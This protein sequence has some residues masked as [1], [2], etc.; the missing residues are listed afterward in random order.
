MYLVTTEIGHP[1]LEAWKYPLPEDSVIFRISRVIIHVDARRVVRLQMPPDQHR[2]T[3]CDH[4]RCGGTWADIDWA[5]DGSAVAFV[6]TS[7]DHKDEYVR[8]ADA[9]NGEVR[10]VF[11]EHVASFFESGYNAVNWRWLPKSNEF[12]WYSQRDNWGH[13][14]L[15]DATTGELKHQVTSGDW[16]VLQ[17]RRIDEEHRTLYFT[18]AGREPGDPYFQYFYR[19]G[20][21]WQTTSCA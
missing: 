15:Y 13:L 5:E 4:V 19:I 14:Y 10:D 3:I 6:S 17:L 21:R 18:G 2:S 16:N 8:I 7:R 12:I 9:E 11:E 1:E 20:P